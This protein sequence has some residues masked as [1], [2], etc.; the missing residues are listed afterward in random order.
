MI[1]NNSEPIPM[2]AQMI[3]TA[4]KSNKRMMMKRIYSISLQSGLLWMLKATFITLPHM[5]ARSKLWR[6]ILSTIR[7]IGPSLK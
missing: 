2:K 5:M 3:T 4:K 6:S 1:K 7:T